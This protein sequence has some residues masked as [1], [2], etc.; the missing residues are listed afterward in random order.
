M[1]FSDLTL[2]VII[3]FGDMWSLSCQAYGWGYAVLQ[4]HFLVFFASHF[5]FI[6]SHIPH[7][8]SNLGMKIEDSDQVSFLIRIK[9][10]V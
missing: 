6:W 4:T 7:P 9:N 3:S 1:P 10:Q 2:L 8:R 5:F